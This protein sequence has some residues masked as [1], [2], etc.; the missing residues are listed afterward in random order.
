MKKGKQ[1]SSL[2]DEGYTSRGLNENEIGPWAQFCADCFSYKSNP[3][4]ASYFERHYYNDPSRNA[5]F[6]R[7][8]FYKG[9]IVSSVRIFV[10]HI[11]I[12]TSAVKAGG[13]GE[14]C[15]LPEHRRRGLSS[16]LLHNAIQIMTEQKMKLSLLHAAPAFFPVYEKSGY[17][18]VVSQWSTLTVHLSNGLN[19]DASSTRLAKFPEDTQQLQSIHQKYSE[20]RFLGCI[21]RNEAYWNEYLARE[22]EGSLYVLLQENRIVAW[23]SVRFRNE[24]YQIR[25][26]GVEGISTSMA[27]SSLLQ[28]A[29]S[30]EDGHVELCV[31]TAVLDELQ[32]EETSKDALSFVDWTSARSD[33]DDGWMYRALGENE[34]RLHVSMTQT[35]PYLLWPAD[36]F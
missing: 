28:R 6:V 11:S 10:R 1:I 23:I 24:K 15:T 7:V 31:P 32:K 5:L 3:P 21:V 18:N 16:R 9:H 34:D 27:L 29:I 30:N 33:N 12:G 22:L 8:M 2:E 13:I 26:F 35:K 17:S 4:P 25:E 36:S 20:Q 14:V 19:K